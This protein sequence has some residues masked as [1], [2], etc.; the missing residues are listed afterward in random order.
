MLLEFESQE[1]LIKCLVYDRFQFCDVKNTG[2]SGTLFTEILEKKIR[3]VQTA[4]TR[5]ILK[6]CYKI[7]HF[8][9]LGIKC[10]V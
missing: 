2:V 8:L 9:F 1:L 4:M 5:G 10:N 7:N 6:Y 3:Y